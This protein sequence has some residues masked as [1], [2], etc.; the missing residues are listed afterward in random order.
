MLRKIGGMPAHPVYVHFPIAFFL[1]GSFFLALFLLEGTGFKLSRVLKKIGIGSFDF[2]S[3]SFILILIGFG[4]GMVAVL[5]GLALV[6][7]WKH[8]PFPHAPLGIATLVCYFIALVMRWVFGPSL[9]IRPVRFLYY[10]LMFAGAVLVS[11]AGFEGG[12]LHYH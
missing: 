10:G 6:K 4:M 5:S 7:G 2:E 3:F 11:L 8:A 1:L 9:F 12:E